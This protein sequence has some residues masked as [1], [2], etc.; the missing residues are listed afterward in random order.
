MS[1][2]LHNAGSNGI[3]RADHHDGNRFRD[4]LGCTDRWNGR[5]DDYIRL[6]LQEFI[7]QSWHLRKISR[8]EAVLK[9]NVLV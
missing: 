9:A 7:D 5:H 4:L 1:E 3:N 8:S 2:T 6:H